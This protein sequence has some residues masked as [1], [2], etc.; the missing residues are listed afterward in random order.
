M[1]GLPLG[2]SWPLMQ[3]ELI[4]LFLIGQYFTSFFNFFF[5]YSV[6]KQSITALH[7]VQVAGCKVLV[8]PHIVRREN[9]HSQAGLA[10]DCPPL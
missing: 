2:M 4:N 8:C 10:P 6:L 9:S 5:F 1:S 3:F 7:V